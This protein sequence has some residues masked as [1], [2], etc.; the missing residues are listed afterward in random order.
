MQ[1]WILRFV[2]VPL[3]RLADY[4]VSGK[5]LLRKLSPAKL[6]AHAVKLAGV[7][8]EVY[9]VPTVEI[10]KRIQRAID[11]VAKV[12][13]GIV[14]FFA[15][16][17]RLVRCLVVDLLVTRKV[18]VSDKKRPSPAKPLFIVG[19]PRSGTTLLLELLGKDQTHWRQ[20]LTEEALFPVR[21]N[22]SRALV[23]QAHNWLAGLQLVMDSVKHIHYESW[24]GPTEC[25]SALENGLGAPYIFWYLFGAL[26]A[27]RQWD[28]QGS[29]YDFYKQQLEILAHPSDERRWLLKDP[30][31]C[32]SLDALFK[33]F[34]DA[35][36]VMTSR[37]KKKAA[38]SMCSLEKHIWE[39][40]L[41]AGAT[42]DYQKEVVDVLDGMMK[43]ASEY[44]AAHPAANILDVSMEQDLVKDPIGTVEKI[45]DF[46]GLT[47]S[48]TAKSAMVS[49][50]HEAN[51]KRSKMKKHTY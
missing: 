5:Q 25:R 41:K 6:R 46:A 22:A 11:A 42:H 14:G 9:H 3:G 33:T 45:Y 16:E 17:R 48:P 36:V 27:L 34:P 10:D 12:D 23:A 8:D 49:F 40:T 50:L 19:P 43:K 20:L 28:H 31:H 1:K 24:D 39:T 4:L 51:K 21:E 29:D 44:R 38:A 15:L 2:L 18:S 32:F 30:A 7:S 13:V 37:D 26:D 35:C 47:L